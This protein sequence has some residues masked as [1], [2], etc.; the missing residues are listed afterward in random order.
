M[1]TNQ[2]SPI[3]LSVD[4]IIFIYPIHSTTALY[5]HL[6]FFLKPLQLLSYPHLWFSFLF[7]LTQTV[8]GTQDLI[9]LHAVLNPAFY[10]VT[11]DEL[12]LVSH[13]SS[14]WTSVFYPSLSLLLKDITL[15][16]SPFS[17]IIISSFTISHVNTSLFTSL[18]IISFLI[19]FIQNIKKVL[20]IDCYT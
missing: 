14:L 5:N 3:E 9:Y 8:S 17:Y 20:P 11:M 2:K 7:Y 15:E 18:F 6:Y 16:I 10:F 12:C 19:I 1:V 4:Y 13:K